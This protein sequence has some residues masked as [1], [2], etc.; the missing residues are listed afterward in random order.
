MGVHERIRRYRT[1]GAAADLVRVEVLVPAD[2]RERVLS[3]AQRLRDEHRREKAIRSVNAEA[4]NDRAKRMIHRLLA[5]RMA[6]DPGI[7]ER[8]RETVARAR[9]A[10]EPYEHLGEWQ[11][12]LSRDPAEIRRTI[13]M[14]SARMTRLRISS[15]LALAAAVEAPDLRRRIWRKAREGLAFRVG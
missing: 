1:T 9:A 12:L 8:A 11:D 10:G 15:P 5:R 13:T 7:V 2:G 4:V 14:R 3:L 6:S